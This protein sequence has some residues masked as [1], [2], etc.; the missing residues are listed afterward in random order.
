MPGFQDYLLQ[1]PIALQAYSE[2]QSYGGQSKPISMAEAALVSQDAK[3]Q[4]RQEQIRQSLPAILS[5]V[6]GKSPEETF[7]ILAPAL[8][9]KIALQWAQQKRIQEQEQFMQQFLTGGMA[10]ISGQGG[11]PAGNPMTLMMAGALTGNSDLMQLGGAMQSANQFNEQMNFRR[12]QENTDRGNETQKRFG[13]LDDRYS[14]RIEDY[15]GIIGDYNASIDLAKQDDAA[16]DYQLIKMGVQAYDKKASAVTDSEFAQQL[17]AGSFVTTVKRLVG[18]YEEGDKLTPDQRKSLIG[19][20][21]IKAEQNRKRIDKI[22]SA[23]E[24]KAK[25]AG[26]DFSSIKEGYD[27]GQLRDLSELDAPAETKQPAATLDPN[28]P[29]LGEGDQ[30]IYEQMPSGTEFYDPQGIKRVKP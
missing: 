5:Q 17:N 10:G 16:A 12:D 26:V 7:A 28:I 11:A 18:Q 30:Y 20:I 23:F 22:N 6:E 9:P 19:A 13:D 24:K 25:A 21:K 4:Q 15:S 3:E 2:I 1:N 29:Q 14:K 8:G 27:P